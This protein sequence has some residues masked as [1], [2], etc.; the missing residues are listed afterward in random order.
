MPIGAS[1]AYSVVDLSAAAVADLDNDPE[2]VRRIRGI[3]SLAFTSAQTATD[4]IW[5]AVGIGTE[6]VNAIAALATPDPFFE[7][8]W[9]GWLYHEWHHVYTG[10]YV[11]PNS[12][13]YSPEYV[14]DSRA[15]RRLEDDHL[16][17]AVAVA[18]ANTT[19]AIGFRI[20]FGLRWL[21]SDSSRR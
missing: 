11:P 16:F 6:S 12:E 5:L 3:W 20:N 8:H 18:R 13:A 15:Q 9:D 1:D 2:T 17:V 4:E 21:L 19:T 14:I 10:G 7:A